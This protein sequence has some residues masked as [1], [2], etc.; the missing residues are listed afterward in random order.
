MAWHGMAWH[1]SPGAAFKAGCIRLFGS[2]AHILLLLCLLLLL[3]LAL[4]LLLLEF[5]TGH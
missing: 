1:G 5:P 2:N 3:P 4:L